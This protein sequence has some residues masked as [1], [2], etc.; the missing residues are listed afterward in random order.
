MKAIFNGNSKFGGVYK[1]YNKVNGH[2]Y[3]GST[4]CFKKRH[5]QHSKAL[6]ENTH[7]N[8]HL[9]NSYNLYGHE[10]FVFEVIEKI[11]VS[12]GEEEKFMIAEQKLIDLHWDGGIACYNINKQARI[13]FNRS[14]KSR[15]L[16][17]EHKAKISASNSGKTLTDEHRQKIRDNAKTNPNYGLRGK[18]HSK[19]TKKKISQG[20][21]GKKHWHYG[22]KFKHNQHKIYQ[23]ELLAPDGTIYTEIT[24]ISDFAEEHGLSVTGLKFLIKKERR[25]HKGWRLVEQPPLLPKKDWSEANS[26]SCGRKHSEETKKKISEVQLGKTLEERCGSKEKALC[27]IKARVATMKKFYDN[28]PEFANRLGNRIRGKSLEETYGTDKA[29]EIKQK[30]S[31]RMA[32]TYSGFVLVDPDGNEYT[33]ITNLRQFCI[34][35]KLDRA[36]LYSLLNGELKSHKGWTLLDAQSQLYSKNPKNPGTYKKVK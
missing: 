10:S 22:K 20:R 30:R 19:A 13:K 36:H 21:L 18:H 17:P 1:I 5:Y 23:T 6:S 26:P 25:F 16:S 14:C 32:K 4:S 15:T 11:T 31:E 9:Q 35:H 7:S 28:N 24:N 2:I 34:K 27:V 12:P 3:I 29:K 8:K 33:E